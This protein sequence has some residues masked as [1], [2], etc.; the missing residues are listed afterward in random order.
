MS[1]I[2]K[3]ET[4]RLNRSKAVPTELKKVEESLIKIANPKRSSNAAEE[5]KFISL[6]DKLNQETAQGNV[7]AE[8][9]LSAAI[10]VRKPSNVKEVGDQ[11]SIDLSKV[12]SINLPTVN[13][14]QT[15]SFEDYDIV[16]NLWLENYQQSDIPTTSSSRKEWIEEDIKT[17]SKAITLLSSSDPNKVNEGLSSVSDIVPFFLIGGFSESEIIAYLKAKN[18]AAKLSLEEII[19]DQ[20]NQDT[21][22]KKSAQK[23]ASQQLSRE[24]EI[25]KAVKH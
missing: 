5:D 23:T 9:I 10:V 14:I 24:V 18:T 25:D 1:D 6:Q 7:L 22:L 15:V 19:K 2:V 3:F 20:E 13:Q 8:S 4:A 21:L 16:K 11:S 12:P 17:I